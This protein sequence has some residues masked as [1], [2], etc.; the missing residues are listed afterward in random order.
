MPALGKILGAVAHGE[1]LLRKNGLAASRGELYSRAYK[2]MA[3]LPNVVLDEREPSTPPSG[4]GGGG[5][6]S[7]SADV[8]DRGIDMVAQA[9]ARQAANSNLQSLADEVT[10]AMHDL[11]MFEAVGWE[12]VTDPAKATIIARVEAALSAHEAAGAPDD[13]MGEMVVDART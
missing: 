4:G 2:A 7:G 6:G 10:S 1:G 11:H 13:R 12:G 3:H 5:S 8:A 9:I